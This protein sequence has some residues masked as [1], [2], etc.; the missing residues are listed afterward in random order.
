MMATVSIGSGTPTLFSPQ[1]ITI[2]VGDTVVW[3]CMGGTHTSTAF[4]G[5]SEYWDSGMMTGGMMGGS[6][7]WTF[8]HAGNFTY[9]S[10]AAGDAGQIGWIFVQQ[11]APEFPGIALYVTVAA[12]IVLALLIERRVRA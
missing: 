8:T 5:Q 2:N 7:S 6:F 9:M 3:S 1:G 4:P 11:P 12:A 10:T